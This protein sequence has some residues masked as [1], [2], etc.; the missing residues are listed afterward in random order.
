MFDPKIDRTDTIIRK[1]KE[2][3][4]LQKEFEQSKKVFKK[5]K[6]MENKIVQSKEF[7]DFIDKRASNPHTV[8]DLKF[9]TP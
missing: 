9:R 4:K 1:T 5:V 3:R 8:G 7:G 6:G 2:E